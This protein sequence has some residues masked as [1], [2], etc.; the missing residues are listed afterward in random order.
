VVDCADPSAEYVI[1]GKFED[2]VDDSQCARF[3]ETVASYTE[4]RK[5]AKTLLCLG[6]NR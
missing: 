3:P 4:Q 6:E 5:S 2:T 1:I